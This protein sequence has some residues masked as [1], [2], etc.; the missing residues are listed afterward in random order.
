MTAT[1]GNLLGLSSQGSALRAQPSLPE[2][3]PPL[4]PPSLPPEPPPP[5][6]P[7]PEPPPS[8]PLELLPPLVGLLLDPPSLPEPPPSLG[9]LDDPPSP[10]EV[11]SSDLGALDEPLSPL[12]ESSRPP[13]PGSLLDVG[14]GSLPPVRPR[15]SLELCPADGTAGV[16]GC[17]AGTDG[18]GST[19]GPP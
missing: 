6:P 13:P 12:P 10:P 18:E 5:E 2:P 9:W 17:C 11:G 16:T 3:L 15:S 7:P 19:G 14:L 1:A 4:E 8:P